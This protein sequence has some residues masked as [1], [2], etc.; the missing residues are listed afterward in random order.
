MEIAESTHG[1]VNVL[2]PLEPV[3]GAGANE[4]V[5]RV[6]Q[7]MPTALGRVAIDCG[8]VTHVDSPGLE[9]FVQIAERLANV[10]YALKLFAV[11]DTL[12]EI[13]ELTETAANFEFYVDLNAATR[14]YL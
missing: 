6:E 9:A 3:V 7:A 8:R 14:S 10:G 12:R 1:A 2:K 11:N 13:F 5:A 4:L